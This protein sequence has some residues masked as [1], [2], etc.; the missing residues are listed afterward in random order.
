MIFAE[1]RLRLRRTAGTPGGIEAMATENVKPREA[2]ILSV[3]KEIESGSQRT[4]GGAR[5]PVNEAAPDPQL[6]LSSL[7]KKR[8]L[9]NLLDGYVDKKDIADMKNRLNEAIVD[10]ERI[11]SE[12]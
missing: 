12:L 1:S 10:L 9:I 5:E 11:I 4:A 2:D 7:Q 8:A 3:I 6:L